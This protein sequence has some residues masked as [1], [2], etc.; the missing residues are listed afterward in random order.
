LYETHRLL[1]AR[2]GVHHGWEIPERFAGA[3]EEAAG[4]RDRVGVTDVSWM[5]KLDLKGFALNAPP[6]LGRAAQCWH[7]GACHYLVTCEPEH[8][9]S[10]LEGIRALEGGVSGLGL[11]PPVY[12][13]EV[14]SVYT[15][16]M[17]AGP[18]SHP[19]LSKLTSL[20]TSDTA[21][22]DGGCGQAG[23]AHVHATVLRRDLSGL[24]A[25]LL[26]VSRE[27]GESVWE[28]LLHAGHEFHI[29]P[30]GLEAL[31]ELTA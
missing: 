19:V 5:T 1:G 29:A 20:N 24:P 28:S 6:A 22:P 16:L 11:P 30:F 4:V 27:Y 2:F 14:S 15:A 9:D 18:Q 13:T 25:F 10:V 8:R 17:L 23:L 12:W 3:A 26:L 21:L 31:W 7:L